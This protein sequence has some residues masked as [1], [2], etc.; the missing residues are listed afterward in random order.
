MVRKLLR[1]F[2]ETDHVV[3]KTCSGHPSTLEEIKKIV[4]VKVCGSLKKSA[5]GAI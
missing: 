4:I 2:E 5:S 3:D 1:M